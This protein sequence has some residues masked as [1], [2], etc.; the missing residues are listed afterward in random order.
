MSSKDQVRRSFG[1]AATVYD[2]YAV[3]QQQIVEKLVRRIQ[4]M[5]LPSFEPRILEIGSGTGLL[6][7]K[8]QALWPHAEYV[9]TDINHAMVDVARRQMGGRSTTHYAAADASNLP[10][11]CKFDLIVS[12]MILHW[13]PDLY[14]AMNAISN[15]LNPGAVFAFTILE[16]K[17]FS[18]WRAACDKTGVECGLWDY[19]SLDEIKSVPGMFAVQEKIQTFFDDAPGFL[20]SFKSIGSGAP[21]KGYSGLSHTEMKRVLSEASRIRPFVANYEVI[22]GARQAADGIADLPNAVNASS[23]TS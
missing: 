23:I 16:K 6:T 14:G 1:K 22:Y 5:A 10:F 8:M 19:P 9:V 15:L 13:L 3:V 18:A 21:K 17:S 2:D 7:R 20:H 11:N 12:S 4:H